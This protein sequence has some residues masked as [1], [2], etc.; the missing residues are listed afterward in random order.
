[1]G[2]VDR[3]GGGQPQGIHGCARIRG[4]HAWGWIE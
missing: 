3:I 2:W 4:G 1:M